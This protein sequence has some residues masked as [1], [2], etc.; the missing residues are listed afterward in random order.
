MNHITDNHEALLDYLYEEGDAAERLRVATHLQ[1]CA[2]CAVAVLEFQNVR[3]M[4]S[5]WA[6]PASQLG[7][8]MVQDAG[9][10]SSA[11][12][13]SPGASVVLPGTGETSPSAT[14]DQGA[15]SG[16]SWGWGPRTPKESSRRWTGQRARPLFQAAAAILLFVSGMAVSQIHVEYENG[17]LRMR[18]QSARSEAPPPVNSR[19]GWITLPPDRGLSEYELIR[20]LVPKLKNASSADAE[21]LLQRVRSMIDQSEQRQQRELALRVSQVAR[22]V[23]T[24]HQVDVQRIE[25]NFGRQQDATMDYLVKTSGGVK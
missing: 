12:A 11:R 18:M 14:V 23:E 8:R 4:L 16:W 10:S 13:A 17:E 2:A 5:D 22:E 25:Q 19:M 6:P 20:D 7:L 21:D 24:Q 15:R 9:A 3:G 1:E